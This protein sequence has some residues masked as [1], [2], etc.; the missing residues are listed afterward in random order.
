MPSFLSRETRYDISL[1]E[2]VGHS[3]SL[4]FP[5]QANGGLEWATHIYL[6]DG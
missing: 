6:I 1:I 4:A 5:T 2:R 3:R